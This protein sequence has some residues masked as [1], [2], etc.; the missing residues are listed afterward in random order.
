VIV[1]DEFAALVAA[2]PELH[3]VFADLAA[4]GRSLG[5]HL[6]LCTQRPAGV[7]RDAV[8]ANI[9]LRISLRVTDRGDSIA[10]VGDD[11][12][13]RLPGEPRGRAV[14]QRDREV[15]TL[16]VA[17]SSPRD[18]E[19]IVQA[20]GPGIPAR[21][22]LDP[23]PAVI[24]LADIPPADEPG[25][26]LGVLDLPGAQRQPAA[27]Y[28]PERYGHLLVLGAAGAGASTALATLSAGGDALVVSDDP[29]DAWAQLARPP[30]QGLL[31]IDGLDALV[32]AAGPDLGHDLVEQLAVLLRARSPAV[33]VSARRLGGPV[34]AIA[35]LFGSRLL[36]RQSS[37]DEHLLAGGASEAF[38]PA[39]PPGAGTWRG[40]VIQV[41]DSGRALPAPRLPD[42]PRVTVGDDPVL[43][44][45]AARPQAIDL[46][47]AVRVVRVGR[48]PAPELDV[49]PGGRPT[50]LLGD[51]DAWQSEWALLTEVRRAAPI[52][53]FGCT[54]ADHRV[55]LREA[56]APPPLGRRAGECWL[57]R[58]GATVRAV[59]EDVSARES[60][61]KD[62]PNR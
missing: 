62:P 59:F 37:R 40:D 52:V 12:A 45:V 48:E 9:G 60:E 38:D 18:A 54:A 4:R 57:S 7:V 32:A 39:A 43:A 20:A 10:M 14:L 24:V 21:P 33:A 16:Q 31:V 56:Q 58:D 55:L 47:R 25:R 36:L 19:R 50:V 3:E 6:I 22:W 15:C 42:L 35:G 13:A 28:D 5:L 34:T 41:G 61:E 53:L 11:A 46:G 44:V 29:A 51:P 49:G 30:E 1:V 23:L 2:S 27:V 26:L 17:V 8:L